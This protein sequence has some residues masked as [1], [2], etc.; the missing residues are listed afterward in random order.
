MRDLIRKV[1][2]EESNK[3]V[4]FNTVDNSQHSSIC[5]KFNV[6]S[7]GEILQLLSKE[8]LDFKQKKEISRVLQKLNKDEDRLPTKLDTLDTYFHDIQDIVCKK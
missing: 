4:K 8:N 7:I 5:D 2:K 6:N 3:V 1:L